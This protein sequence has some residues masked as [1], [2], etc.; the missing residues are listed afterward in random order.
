[1]RKDMLMAIAAVLALSICFSVSGYSQ[2]QSTTNKEEIVLTTYYP[3]PFG[4]Y[5]EMRAEH[6][7]V[8]QNYRSYANVCW[9]QGKC[10]DWINEEGTGGDTDL[11]VEGNVGIGNTY[12]PQTAVPNAKTG[13]LD[14]ND[15][16]LRNG[17]HWISESGM[18][19]TQTDV[20]QNFD[21]YFETSFS[22][23]PWRDIA[24][25]RIDLPAGK[26][27]VIFQDNIFHSGRADLDWV[28]FAWSTGATR[29]QALTGASIWD[30]GT[31]LVLMEDRHV[32][33]RVTRRA[34]VDDGVLVANPIFVGS[35]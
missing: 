3:T 19:F 25:A 10:T 20:P 34:F 21:N 9:E 7:A 18:E 26:Y 29:A 12:K 27:L 17:E 23:A 15:V 22:T 1:M 16:W 5:R 30:T 13:N 33:V 28:R 35:F 11:I 32:L 31:H 14:V 6:M 24:S 8:G 4:D 2:T